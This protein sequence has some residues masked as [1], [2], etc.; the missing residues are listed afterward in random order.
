MFDAIKD[1]A[2][3]VRRIQL[4]RAMELEEVQQILEA[5]LVGSEIGAPVVKRGIMGRSIVFPEVSRVIP[6][7]SVKGDVATLRKVTN[8]SKS[9]IGV[10]KA[11]FTLT[12]DRRGRGLI[13]S[14]KTG[15]EYFRAV[16]AA[17]ESALTDQ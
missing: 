13:D 4:P 16:A 15:S 1:A 9:S 6:H 8:E 7:L 11:S 17:V 5:A 14:V 3:S 12:R 2:D 10:G